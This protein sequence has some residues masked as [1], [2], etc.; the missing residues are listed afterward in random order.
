MKRNLALIA[1]LAGLLPAAMQ[2]AEAQQPAPRPAAPLNLSPQAG[3]AAAPMP[4]A[5]VAPQPAFVPAPPLPKPGTVVAFDAGQ[6]AIVTRVNSYFNAMPM[7]SGDFVQVAADGSRTTGRFFILKPGKVRFEYAAPSK[8]ELIGDGQSLAVRDRSLNTQD[9]YPLS[10]T[11]LRFLLAEKLDL[12]R[13]THVV[14][15]KRDEIYE[16][17]VLEEK[18]ALG[19]THRLM[20]LFGAQDGQLKQWTVTDAQGYDTTVAVANLDTS[21]KP[22]PKLFRI[23]YERVLQ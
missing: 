5:P 14:A 16:S 15:V 3:Q 8:V 1:V 4:T 19:G 7:L 23:N 11:P 9:L 6:R 22:D 12:L 18:Q 10:Q 17:V 21:R 20:L 13:D 2:P